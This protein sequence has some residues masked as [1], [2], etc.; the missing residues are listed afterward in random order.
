M[1]F[2]KRPT[3]N[4]NRLP[5]PIASCRRRFRNQSGLTN[6]IRVNHPDDSDSG[7]DSDSDGRP[8]DTLPQRLPSPPTEAQNALQ[9]Q[10][11]DE[12][13]NQRTP[14]STPPFSPLAVPQPSP[15]PSGSFSLGIDQTPQAFD[16]VRSSSPREKSPEA[17]TP[18]G[19]EPILKVYHPVING[20]YISWD[21]SFY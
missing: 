18:E 21:F 15:G 19:V 3:H 2:S 14:D 12:P 7:L 8:E 13:F 9:I 6:H 17:P 4:P 20:M 16:N 1:S 11:S 10:V 5:C